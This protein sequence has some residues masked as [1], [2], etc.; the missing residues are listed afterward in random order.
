MLSVAAISLIPRGGVY[1]DIFYSAE[2]NAIA[3]YYRTSSDFSYQFYSM[4]IDKNLEEDI[5]IGWYTNKEMAEGG[6]YIYYAYILETDGTGIDITMEEFRKFDDETVLL[7]FTEF[8]AE[9]NRTLSKKQLSRIKSDLKIP[10]NIKVTSYTVSDIWYRMSTDSWLTC[11]TLYNDDTV[12]GTAS[13]NPETYELISEIVYYDEAISITG[14]IETET[15]ELTIQVTNESE[16]TTDEYAVAGIAMEI[17]RGYPGDSAIITGYDKEENA[18]WEYQTEAYSTEESWLAIS[19]IGWYADKYFFAAGDSII[20]LNAYTGELIWENSDYGG[21]GGCGPCYF[22]EDA[23]YVCGHDQPDFFAVSYDGETIYRIDEID[24][25]TFL[26]YEM[27]KQED[28]SIWIYY[29][30]GPASSSTEFICSVDPQT[31]EYKRIS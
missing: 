28:G 7:E 1:S 17:E 13:V 9:Y 11:V 10:D 29:S 12:I 8:E 23:L 6:D 30:S 21:N 18:V 2:L 27:E 15:I 26:P 25:Y 5:C 14:A 31:W 16:G 4:N 3:T 20:A 24:E 22:A 19:E